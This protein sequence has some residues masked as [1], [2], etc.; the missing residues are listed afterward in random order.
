M[1][2]FV[3]TSPSLRKA[4]WVAMATMHF[5]VAQKRFIYGHSFGFRVSQE[6]IGHQVKIVL[7]V[8]GW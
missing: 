3:G 6:T 7:G 1:I 8:Q 4:L 5:H 2:D